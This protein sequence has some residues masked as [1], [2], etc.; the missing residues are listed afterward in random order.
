MHSILPVY[1]DFQLPPRRPG[2]SYLWNSILVCMG[3]G[4]ICCDSPLD[5]SWFGESWTP[6]GSSA[7]RSQCPREHCCGD[8][9]WRN[10]CW[11]WRWGRKKWS[12]RWISSSLRSLSRKMLAGWEL[13][14]LAWKARDYPDS[15][16]WTGRKIMQEELII[17]VIG[18]SL[19]NAIW[20]N[21]GS[22]CLSI[23]E[24]MLLSWQQLE[25][26]LSQH[27]KPSFPPGEMLGKEETPHFSRMKNQRTDRVWW[28]GVSP[29][30]K[31]SSSVLWSNFSSA[32]FEA[33]LEAQ[34]LQR[35]RFPTPIQTKEMDRRSRIS[36]T[37]AYYFAQL[38][39]LLPLEV[40]TVAIPFQS[41]WAQHCLVLRYK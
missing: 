19:R 4:S 10:G 31:S 28:H 5:K 21:R 26:C 9:G 35:S 40:L 33:K 32:S 17:K 39:L 15:T 16:F 20:T 18:I 11:W 1:P 27:S 34:I 24:F 38:Y 23:A 37:K 41:I 14:G 8:G 3:A 29:L 2:K 25:V 6:Q 36:L 13:G 22:C 12:S 7:A 30:I